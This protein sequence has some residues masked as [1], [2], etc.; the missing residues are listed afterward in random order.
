MF[1]QYVRRK[2]ESRK[3]MTRRPNQVPTFS[4]SSLGAAFVTVATWEI[5]DEIN[6]TFEKRP[7]QT[8]R[9]IQAKSSKPSMVAPSRYFTSALPGFGE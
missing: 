1:A 2:E 9:C 3:S 7:V 4:A 8:G 6:T 5:G